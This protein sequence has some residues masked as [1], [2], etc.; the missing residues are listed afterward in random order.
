MRGVVIAEV[1]TRRSWGRS[2]PRRWL[3]GSASVLL[4][5]HG[6]GCKEF[7]ACGICHSLSVSLP[8]G[9]AWVHTCLFPSLPVLPPESWPAPLVR[10]PQTSGHRCR[11][12]LRFSWQPGKPLRGSR[13]SR[14]VRSCLLYTSDAADEEDSVDL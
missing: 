14:Y 9:S 8:G 12:R 6:R 10:C 2:P 13:S 5:P 7:E 4:A 3:R 1:G 11:V